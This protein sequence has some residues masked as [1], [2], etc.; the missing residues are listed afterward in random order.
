M[1]KITLLL[2]LITSSVFAQIDYSKYSKDELISKL[3]AKDLEFTNLK[4]SLDQEKK[5]KEKK[6]NETT[7]TAKNV[8]DELTKI[9]EGTNTIFLREIFDAKYVKNTTYFKETDLAI[10]NNTEKFIN[11]DVLINSIK[12]NQT[13]SLL[14]L[15]NKALDFNKNYLALFDI[16]D[17]VLNKK[18]DKIKV[19]TAI[20]AIENLPELESDSKL[21]IK[22]M[23]IVNL[24]KNYS[25]NICLLRNNLDKL[26]TQ[27][28][29]KSLAPTYL[30]L[31][32]ESRY[33]DYPFL[34]SIISEMRKDTNSYTNDDLQPCAEVKIIVETP[35]K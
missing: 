9:I 6:S 14:D 26:K 24:L 16:R 21:N 15:C 4:K 18:F 1:K 20:K 10:E 31:E 2:L 12:I 27:K 17:N 33:K 29:Q 3:K 34:Q 35:N 11:S 19:L 13:N 5:A 22:K 23:K 8:I 25:E 28:D 30:K 7:S 32:K